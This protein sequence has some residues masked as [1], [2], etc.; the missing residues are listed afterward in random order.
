MQIAAVRG[1][2]GSP[3][4]ECKFGRMVKRVIDKQELQ[5]G[6]CWRRRGLSGTDVHWRGGRKSWLVVR[7]C[8]RCSGGGGAISW[9]TG[10]RAVLMWTKGWENKAVRWCTVFCS[11]SAEL[12]CSYRFFS[13]CHWHLLIATGHTVFTNEKTLKIALRREGLVVPIPILEAGFWAGS[14]LLFDRYTPRWLS[15]VLQKILV[16]WS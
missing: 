11:P 10:H 13:T 16:T 3:G 6:S 4:A 1:K 14:E 5:E 15:L 7:L 8:S 2:I 9:G 12:I